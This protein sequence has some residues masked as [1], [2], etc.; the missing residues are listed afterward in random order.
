M[1]QRIVPEALA[2]LLVLAALTSVCCALDAKV[3]TVVERNV[4]LDLGPGYDIISINVNAAEGILSSVVEVL[5]SGNSSTGSARISI[6]TPYDL[7]FKLIS[8]PVFSE[9][10]IAGL[11]SAIADD[12]KTEIESWSAMDISGQNVTVRTFQ[13]DNVSPTAGEGTM[14]VAF[15]SIDDKSYALIASRFDRNVTSRIIGSLSL[16]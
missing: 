9:L 10:F 15:W 4:S 6:V 7:T 3:L 16:V 2:L 13:E 14:D 1:K 8:P 12:N 11:L 5:G